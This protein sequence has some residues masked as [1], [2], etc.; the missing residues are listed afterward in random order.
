MDTKVC[1]MCNIEKH[2][3]DFNKNYTE[4]KDCYG[5]RRLKRYYDNKD[6]ISSHRIIP[7]EKNKEKLLQE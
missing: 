1:S 4:C 5:K 7:Y 3:K 2:L 6:K